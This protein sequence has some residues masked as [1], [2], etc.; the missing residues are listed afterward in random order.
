MASALTAISW[1]WRRQWPF[2]RDSRRRKRRTVVSSLTDDKE[3]KEALRSYA[4][5]Q[6]STTKY[7]VLSF[8]PRNLFEQL[9]RFANVYFIFLAALNFVPVVNAF[10]P[11]IGVI[12]I[13]GV[14]TMTAM[15]DLYE[16]LR[17]LKSDRA[18]NNLLCEVYSRYPT[19][20]YTCNS[21][22]DLQHVHII[23]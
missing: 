18:V 15:K 1:P 22:W 4:Q 11:V 13:V 9:H 14:L 16:D 20:S 21:M 19:C 2:V 10:Q 7:T 23:L 8:V 12:P 6:I 17:R 5:N 3:L